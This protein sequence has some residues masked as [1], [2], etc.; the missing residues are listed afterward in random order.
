MLCAEMV[1]GMRRVYE[2]TLEYSKQRVQFGRHIG[3]YQRMQDKMISQVNDLDGSWLMVYEAAWSLSEGLPS[4][5]EVS[6]A[7]AQCSNSYRSVCMRAHELFAG[8]GFMT[9]FDLVPYTMRALL[10]EQYLGNAA[11]HRKIIGRELASLQVG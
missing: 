6:V 7:K 2:M 1:G 4:T 9:D 11:F 5:L 8:V 3:S 10:A